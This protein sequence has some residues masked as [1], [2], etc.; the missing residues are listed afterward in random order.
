MQPAVG[1]FSMKYKAF[2]GAVAAAVVAAGSADAAVVI[3]FSGLPG[4]FQATLP[5]YPTTFVGLFAG[6]L[7]SCAANFGV[8]Y[9]VAFNPSPSGDQVTFT[10]QRPAGFVDLVAFFAAGAFGQ[11]GVYISGT[12][13]L[14]IQSVSNAVPEPATWA[15][16]IGGFSLAGAALRRRQ[17]TRV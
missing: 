10:S 17:T 11:D 1:G 15:L 2:L 13:T 4:T 3:N 8:C 9:S 16:M 14:T 12:D 5:T 7:D 6:E